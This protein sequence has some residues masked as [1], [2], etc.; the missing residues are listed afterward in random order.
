MIWAGKSRKT[1]FVLGAG[2]TRGAV[3]HVLA[4]RKRIK[5]P[6]NRDFFNVVEKFASA[7]GKDQRTR[8]RYFRLR[9]V[10][11]SEFPGKWP[12]PMETA[13][14]LLYVS[15]DFP[16]I[17]AA[18]AGRRRQPGSRREIEDFLRLTFGVLGAIEAGASPQN[19]YS[20][21]VRYLE[22]HDTIITLNYDTVLDQ[23]LIRSGW[24]P[25][26]G[27]CLI[28]GEN[29]IV[30]RKSRVP[31]SPDLAGTKLLK[32]HGSMNWLVKGSYKKV[33]RVFDKKPSQVLIYKSP[34]KNEKSGF[35]RQIIPPIYGKF[36]SHY[37]W[38]SLWGHAY[39][40][41][42][43]AEVI[44]VIGCSLVDTDFHLSGMFGHAIRERK[45]NGHQF[46]CAILVDKVGIRRKWQKL[47]KGN[48]T[49]KVPYR[50]FAKF[51]LGM[52]KMGGASE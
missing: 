9:K 19:L 3:P 41:I 40:S 38:Q 44:V 51:M 12:L 33:H 45:R 1:V 7:D 23:A 11:E 31:P 46:D 17:Y 4:N 8:K 36:F 49:K 13:F 30:P 21:L 52:K 43:G 34:S 18:G 50:S 6:L 2:A 27:Y 5:P 26:K 15:K 48:I 20:E 22:S 10:L 42:I 14:S 25:G 32:L 37:H 28:G 24:P 16:E 29:K 39:K 47:L 35:I